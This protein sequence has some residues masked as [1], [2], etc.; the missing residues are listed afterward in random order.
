M[1]RSVLYIVPQTLQLLLCLAR[2]TISRPLV[3]ICKV[4]HLLENKILIYRAAVI[5]ST[6]ILLTLSEQLQFLVRF[7]TVNHNLL[8]KN[9]YL[10]TS[11]E[12]TRATKYIV[13]ESRYKQKHASSNIILVT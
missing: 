8:F 12:T 1:F 6:T 13:H 4:C 9:I 7:W 2:I 11:N 10:S 5:T 3:C